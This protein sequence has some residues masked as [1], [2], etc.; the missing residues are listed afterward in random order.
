MRFQVGEL[1]TIY[2]D[3]RLSMK[4]VEKTLHERV[5][6]SIK[7]LTPVILYHQLL[8]NLHSRAVLVSYRNQKVLYIEF[9]PNERIGR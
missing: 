9:L 2:Y 8:G 7:Q 5:N 6:F 4:R 1:I 3:L